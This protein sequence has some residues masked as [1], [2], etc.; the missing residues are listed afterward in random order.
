MIDKTSRLRC[1]CLTLQKE[2]LILAFLTVPESLVFL[3]PHLWQAF[4]VM[5]SRAV[6]P[7]FFYRV[8]SERFT[9]IS[10][11]RLQPLV[12]HNMAF[13]G[14]SKVGRKPPDV[15]RT[16]GGGRMDR[17]RSEQKNVTALVAR[18]YPLQIRVNIHS[19]PAESRSRSLRTKA[20]L[21]TPLQQFEPPVSIGM[22]PSGTQHVTV[23]TEPPTNIQS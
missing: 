12:R 22:S 14:I 21:M 6:K 16:V 11:V 10:E 18:L 23:S 1:R 19:V 9:Q 17:E 4:P 20:C 15:R 13:Y 7:I 3:D 5:R 2:I 8:P